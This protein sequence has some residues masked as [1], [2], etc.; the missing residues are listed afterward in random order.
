MAKLRYARVFV[1]KS[2]TTKLEVQ[3]PVWEV[4]VLADVM[5]E[6]ITIQDYQWVEKRGKRDFI[7]DAAAE[8]DRLANKYGTDAGADKSHVVN[9]YGGGSFGLE[10]LAGEIAKNSKESEAELIPAG[11]V[12]DDPFADLGLLDAPRVA[13]GA[14]AIEA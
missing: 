7:P 4:P 1:D 9:A 2:E 14:T 11:D 13:E 6:G 3:V 10:K 5:G 12:S 8:F